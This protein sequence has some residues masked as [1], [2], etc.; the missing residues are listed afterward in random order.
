MGM[1]RARQLRLEAF[2]REYLVDKD[3]RRAALAAGYAEGTSYSLLQEKWVKNRL[4][5][6]AKQQME[7]VDIKADEVLAE[8]ARI[9][10]APVD[11]YK[12][13]D[14]LKALELLAKHFRLLE[15][16]QAP[17]AVTAGAV[18]VVIQAAPAGPPLPAPEPEGPPSDE[19]EAP[20][21]LPPMT[22]GVKP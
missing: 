11:Y 20:A 3:P 19:A 8:L 6:L 4:R 21:A 9:A 2:C 1:T 7:R 16:E 14:K 22:P 5:E 18:Q 10:R 17:I 12:G 13:A 15:P